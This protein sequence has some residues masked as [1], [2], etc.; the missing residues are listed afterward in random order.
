MFIMIAG[1]YTAGSSDKTKWEKN[2][3]ELNRFAYEVYLKG[4]IPVIGVN[5]A[6]PII[7]TVGTD[8]FDELMMPMS[9]AMADRCD[10]VLRIEGSSKGA[11]QEVEIFKRKGLPIYYHLDDI[12]EVK[13]S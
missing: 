13:Q 10:A 2:H 12:P 3:Q 11:D 9:L 7:E 1:P 4:H 5:L 6:L 8:K